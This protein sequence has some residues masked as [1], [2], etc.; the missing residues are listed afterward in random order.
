MVEDGGGNL[1]YVQKSV[2]EGLPDPAISPNLS[3]GQGLSLALDELNIKVYATG[4]NVDVKGN[5]P[6]DYVTIERTW[7]IFAIPCVHM[8]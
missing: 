7:G 8:L 6:P 4:D 5:Y 2:P 3:T 1:R